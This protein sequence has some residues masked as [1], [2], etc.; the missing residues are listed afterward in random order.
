MAVSVSKEQY[1]RACSV[2]LYEFLTKNHGSAV[3]VEYGSA[4]LLVDKH[5]SVKRGFHGYRNFRTNETGNNIDY[6]MNFLNYD[7]QSAVLALTGESGTVSDYVPKVN[8]LVPEGPKEI[9]IPEAV[10]GQYRN[11]YAFLSARKI[12]TD[13]IQLLIDRGILYQ[14]AVGNN[15]VFI[16][17]QRDYYELRGTNTYADR[18]CEKRKECQQYKAGEHNWCQDMD[19]C[20]RYKPDPF[21]GV[22][23]TQKD[24]FWYFAPSGDKPSEEVY[25]CEAAIDAI[26]L[27]VIHKAQKKKETVVYVSIGGVANQSTIDRIVRGGKNVILAVDNDKAGQECREKNPTLKYVLPKNKD[28]NDDLKKGDY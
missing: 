10:Q 27:Y 9:F 4:L 17:P 13:V 15:A 23:K 1:E 8:H 11:L 20:E 12:P 7:Y 5:V 22:Q 26:S 28:W 19:T 14:S 21:H 3:K 25:V 2:D 18:R 16:N 6:L 24:R